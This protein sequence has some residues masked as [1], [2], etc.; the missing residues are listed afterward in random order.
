MTNVFLRFNGDPLNAEHSI[1]K[2]LETTTEE[3]QK[4]WNRLNNQT[5]ME[6]Q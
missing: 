3:N 5:S 6:G 4:L 1:Q 2:A